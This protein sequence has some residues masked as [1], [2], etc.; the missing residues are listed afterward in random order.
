ML[1]VAQLGMMEKKDSI[2][3]HLI[4]GNSLTIFV[5]L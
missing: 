5:H 2:Y 4:V 3:E 1:D